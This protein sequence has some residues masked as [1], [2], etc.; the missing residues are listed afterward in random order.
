MRKLYK[1][2]TWELLSD[3]LPVGGFEPGTRFAEQEIVYMLR[4]HSL[5][6]YSVIQHR[7]HGKFT[8]IEGAQ[9]R[10]PFSLINTHYSACVC[11]QKLLINPLEAR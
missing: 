8:V 7:E 3:P 4:Y 9:N 5:T 2:C 11:N 10:L 6:P 1:S